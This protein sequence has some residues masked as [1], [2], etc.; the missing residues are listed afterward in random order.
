MN[1]DEII[2]D[3]VKSTLFGKFYEQI[4][5]EWFKEKKVCLPEDGKPRIYWKQVDL[6]AEN[7]A[8]AGHL[9]NA[10]KKNKKE[11]QF[12]TPDGF[13]KRGDKVYIWE[14]KNWPQWDEGKKKLKQLEDLLSG[15]PIILSKKAKHKTKELSIDGIMFSWWSKP[16]GIEPILEEINNLIAPRTFEMFY[17]ADILEDCVRERYDWYLRIIEVE[18]ARIDQMFTELS[19]QTYL[20]QRR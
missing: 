14:A 20:P 2:N 8:L 7:S 16:E 10:L 13:M 6:A 18:K 9:N 17:T 4:I 19:G 3:P 11:K 15:L 12:C 5:K 1:A